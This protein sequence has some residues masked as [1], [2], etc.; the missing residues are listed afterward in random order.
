MTIK[1]LHKRGTINFQSQNY[2]FRL[3]FTTQVAIRVRVRGERPTAA[4]SAIERV[5]SGWWV[6][7]LALVGRLFVLGDALRR[8]HHGR[9]LVRLR[10]VLVVLLGGVLGLRR[11]RRLAELLARIRLRVIIGRGLGSV[12]NWHCDQ[13]SPRGGRALIRGRPHHTLVHGRLRRWLLPKGGCT[14]RRTAPRGLWQRSGRL[15][16]ATVSAGADP[17]RVVVS[18]VSARVRRRCRR[19][20]C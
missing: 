10:L 4:H 2:S 1:L 7:P 18:H 20:L 6:L 16:R 12:L 11:W 19:R 15:L 13:I 9:A 8:R 5:G 14:L 3:N 17:T